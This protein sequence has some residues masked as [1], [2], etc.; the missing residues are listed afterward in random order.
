MTIVSVILGIYIV[1][2]T[3]I[4]MFIA[5]KNAE[6]TN[7][8]IIINAQ[9]CISFWI[10]SAGL[11]YSIY[12]YMRW[13]SRANTG[14]LIMLFNIFVSVYI[15]DLLHNM[16]SFDGMMRTVVIGFLAT[17][18]IIVISCF[19]AVSLKRRINSNKK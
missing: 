4:S 16:T 14:I 19:V 17:A 3:I 13:N 9:L 7:I 6:P 5:V 8:G 12:S 15:S 2:M 10:N 11:I 1:A 18:I